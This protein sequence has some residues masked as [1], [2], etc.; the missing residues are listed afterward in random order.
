MDMA[1]KTPATVKGATQGGQTRTRKKTATP[2]AISHVFSLMA[3]E[4]TEVYVAGDFN[5][6]ENH[7]HKMRKYKNGLHKKSIR[8]KPGR[9]E[10]RFVVDGQWWTDPVNQQRCT[11]VFGEDN[12]VVQIG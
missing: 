6:W 7:T 1:G 10:Y 3:P 11:S 9:Y 4:A 12:S 2:A 8:L 5:N